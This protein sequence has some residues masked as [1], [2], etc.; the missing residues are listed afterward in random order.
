MAVGFHERFLVENITAY[1]IVGTIFNAT[2]T[3]VVVA[4]LEEILF[5]GGIF[6]GLRRMIYWPVALFISS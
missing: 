4:T 2:V 1:K 3:A 6:G 5:R